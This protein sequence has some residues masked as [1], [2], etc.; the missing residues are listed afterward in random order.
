[1]LVMLRSLGY[2]QAAQ[3]SYLTVAASAPAIEELQR[4][5]QLYDAARPVDGGER[6]GTVGALTVEHVTFAYTEGRP[7]LRDVSFS[8]RQHEIVGIVGPSGGGKS[9]LVQLLLGLRRPGTGQIL[10]GGRDIAVFDRA[11]WARKVTFVPQ[12]PHLIAGTIVENIRFLREDVTQEEIERAAG[13]AHIHDD[14][15]RF[16]DG[17]LHQAG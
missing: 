12:T 4:R 11:E 17:Y 7:V 13:L 14:I 1:M 10:A 15:E 6:V 3:G 9:T 8:V 16:P 2:G 5:L